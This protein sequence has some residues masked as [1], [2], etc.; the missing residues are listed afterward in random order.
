MGLVAL[1]VLMLRDPTD[2]LPEDLAFAY[3]WCYLGFW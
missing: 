3:R 2:S 1:M